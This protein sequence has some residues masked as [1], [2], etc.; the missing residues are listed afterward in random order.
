MCDLQ[1]VVRGKPL[2]TRSAALRGHEARPHVDTRAG[3]RGTSPSIDTPSPCL[4]PPRLPFLCRR[5]AADLKRKLTTQRGVGALGRLRRPGVPYSQGQESRSRGSARTTRAP[6][7]SP[8]QATEE[9]RGKVL[10]AAWRTAMPAPRKP[11]VQCGGLLTTVAGGKSADATDVP[12]QH[13]C[14]AAR[15]QVLAAVSV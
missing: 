10:V 13:V 6:C 7:G 11:T 1:R 4:C 15:G 5:M 8:R 3:S 14:S 9:G 12:G 2:T